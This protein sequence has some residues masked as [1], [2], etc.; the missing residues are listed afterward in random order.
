M[1]RRIVAE[2][3]ESRGEGS[4]ERTV[5]WQHDEGAAR[6]LKA[7]AYLIEGDVLPGPLRGADLVPTALLYRAMHEGSDLHVDG[8]VTRSLLENLEEFGAAWHLLRPDLYRPIRL[9]A[10]EVAED[11]LPTA[12]VRD[13]AVLTYSGGVD[14]SFTLW[15]HT[16]NRAGYRTRRLATGILVQ[17]MDIPIG[18]DAAFEQAKRTARET[19]QAFDV[20]MTT[21]RTA[22][23]TTAVADWEMEF[24]AGLAAVLRNWEGEAGTGLVSSGG[25]YAEFQIPWGSE[26]TLTPLLSANA[27]AIS[28]DGGTYPRLAKIAAI[29][30][31]EPIVRNLRVCFERLGSGRNCGECEK[32]VRTK[33]GFLAVGAPVPAALGPPP[34]EAR[35]SRLLGHTRGLLSYL[36]AVLDE[37]KRR[38]VD[39]P[40]T[41]ALRQRVW[42]LKAKGVARGFEKRVGS[43]YPQLRSGFRSG[44]HWARSTL[45]RLRA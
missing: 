33:L 42:V 37:C 20:P 26:P 44:Y 29:A 9:T 34:S 14:S 36:E 38:D 30:P 31:V 41:K 8:A 23:R 15:Q 11:R 17:G 32:C 35:I 24:G 4:V 18:A 5:L 12:D 43:Q 6:S 16:Q 19:L 39:E 25:H 1:T 7:V 10:A 3:R 13:T 21:V 2:V 45:E 27:F 40:W 22:W 28:Y